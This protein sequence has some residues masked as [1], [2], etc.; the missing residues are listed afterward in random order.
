[1][2][3]PAIAAGRTAVITGGADGIGLATARRLAASGMRLILADIDAE[4]LASAAKSLTDNGAQAA[5][6]AVDVSRADDIERLR[7]LAFKSG[8]VAFLMNNAGI[9]GGGHAFANPDG[10]RRLLGVNLGGVINAVQAFTQPMI[11]QHAPAVIVNTGSKQGITTPPGDTAYNVS[12]AGIKVLTEGLQHTLRNIEG[13]QV[14][15]HLLVPGFTF[16]GMTRRRISEK[17]PAAWTPDQ[18][19]QFLLVRLAGGDF[20]ILCPDN[21]V[22]R[23]I[24]NARIA[25]AAHD[26]IDNR[27]PLSRWHPDFTAAFEAYLAAHAPSVPAAN[28]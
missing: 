5:F 12:K 4:N 8:D 1:M 2:T 19:A 13:C 15:A 26:I 11:D 25:W 21:D 28:S 16:T 10:W 22:T 27:P 23:E 3:H 24:D 9:G 7:D 17:P 14:S 20:Y 6:L 18:V